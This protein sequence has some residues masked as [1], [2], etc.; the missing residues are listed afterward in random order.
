MN[1]VL[2]TIVFN[3]PW[4]LWVILRLFKGFFFSL[5]RKDKSDHID[6][7]YQVFNLGRKEG[8]KRRQADKYC[9]VINLQLK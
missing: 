7:N 6:E 4:V 9:K 2:Q 5:L 3:V 1:N 8:R